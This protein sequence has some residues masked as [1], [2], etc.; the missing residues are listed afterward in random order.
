MPGGEC[1]AGGMKH[2]RHHDPIT[3]TFALMRLPE[4]FADGDSLPMQP[5]DRWFDTHEEV[6]ATLPDVLNPD[7]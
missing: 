7:E 2:T 5:T 3:H 4:T 6:V 1:R